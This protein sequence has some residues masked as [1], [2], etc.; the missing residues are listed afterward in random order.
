[1]LI[2]T[3]VTISQPSNVT[4]CK[5]RGMLFICVIDTTYTNIRDDNVQWYRFIKNAGTTETVD[6][7]EDNINLLTHTTGNILNSSLS[8]IDVKNP[9]LDTTGWEHHFIMSAMYLSM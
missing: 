8:I 5:G 2:S 6:P 9:L 7:D 4:T 3:T 1:M